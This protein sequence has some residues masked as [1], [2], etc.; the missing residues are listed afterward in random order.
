MRTSRRISLS[1]LVIVL[2]AVAVVGAASAWM[3]GRA[4]STF[5]AEQEVRFAPY[6]DLTLTPAT[7]FEDPVDNQAG[8]VI[9]A[10]VVA[11]PVDGCTPSWGTYYSLDAAGRA[12]DAME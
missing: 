7:H 10:F 6:V 1:R 3:V 8:D 9:L 4:A 11:D 12:L 5:A 2:V